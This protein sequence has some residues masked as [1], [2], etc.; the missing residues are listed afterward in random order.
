MRA[1][2]RSKEHQGTRSCTSRTSAK[3]FWDQLKSQSTSR[4]CCYSSGQPHSTMLLGLAA[5]LWLGERGAAQPFLPGDPL[6]PATGTRSHALRLTRLWL[7]PSHLASFQAAGAAAGNPS[8][9][10]F[11]RGIQHAV[12][13]GLPF[14]PAVPQHCT[15]LH[16]KGVC[17]SH[18]AMALFTASSKSSGWVGERGRNINY[19]NIW[20]RDSPLSFCFPPAVKGMGR[21]RA[22][23]LAG[24][25]FPLAGADEPV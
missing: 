16:P 21:A 1:E 19:S 17:R 13:K 3:C 2:L 8:V 5:H 15:P 7:C 24:G 6:L 20:S 22:R 9:G 12:C 18:A 25:K 10:P 11:C 23:A 14:C 4:A